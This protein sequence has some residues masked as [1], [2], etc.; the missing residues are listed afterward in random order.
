MTGTGSPVADAL[1]DL[2]KTRPWQENV[3]RH[4]H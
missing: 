1:R 4:L 2:G 3:Y